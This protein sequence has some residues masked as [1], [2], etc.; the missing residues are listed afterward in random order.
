M[1]RHVL[2]LLALWVGAIVPLARV[3]VRA[4]QATEV[5]LAISQ[6]GANAVDDAV[7]VGFALTVTHPSAG[8]LGAAVP[9]TEGTAG[10]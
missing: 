10:G 9:R 1:G 4:R 7:A 2:I 3:P 6:S 8:N 5:G